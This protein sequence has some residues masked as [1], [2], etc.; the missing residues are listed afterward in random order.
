MF[1][2]ACKEPFVR[3]YAKRDIAAGEELYVDYGPYYDYHF[4]QQPEVQQHFLRAC[5]IESTTAFEWEYG[6]E[7]ENE[8][9]NENENEEGQE[10]AAEE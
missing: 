4:M 6:K 2:T 5:G 7:K 1:A 3:L 10:D 8:N 9:E